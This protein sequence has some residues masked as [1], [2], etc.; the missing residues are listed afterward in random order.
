MKVTAYKEKEKMRES[1][2]RII[3]RALNQKVIQ[4]IYPK[5]LDLGGIAPSKPLQS[6]LPA[7]EMSNMGDRENGANQLST[8]LLGSWVTTDT[9]QDLQSE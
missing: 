7:E 8:S 2:A 4:S 5:L 3:R 1:L 6:S 9:Q